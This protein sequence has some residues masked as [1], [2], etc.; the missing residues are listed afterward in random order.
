MKLP[1][2][3]GKKI[4]S[5]NEG[6]VEFYAKKGGLQGALFEGMRGFQASKS[7][8]K[9]GYPSGGTYLLMVLWGIWGKDLGKQTA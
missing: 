4:Y 3:G 5:C 7:N 8:R 1:E 6:T 2:G 9:C